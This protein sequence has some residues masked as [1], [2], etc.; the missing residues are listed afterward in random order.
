MTATATADVVWAVCKRG[1]QRIVGKQCN[2]CHTIHNRS[3]I[4]RGRAEGRFGHCADCGVPLS[5]SRTR[6]CEPCHRKERPN[7][8]AL[9]H[10]APEPG[11]RCRECRRPVEERQRRRLGVRTR[12]QWRADVAARKAARQDASTT[13]SLRPTRQAKPKQAKAESILPATWNDPDPARVALEKR[14]AEAKRAIRYRAKAMDGN[15]I[16]LATPEEM[17][18]RIVA[19][20][21]A[22]VQ[23]AAIGV[24]TTDIAF[25]LRLDAA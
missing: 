20:R 7:C 21:R 22:L 6:R 13:R 24:D 14:R 15:S 19:A 3:N 18:P 17:A 16:A 8:E 1:H 2:D 11:K 25:I 23:L 12:D 10:P 5:D 9:G 4:E